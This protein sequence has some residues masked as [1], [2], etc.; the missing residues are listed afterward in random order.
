MKIKKASPGIDQ[1]NRIG[2]I[3]GDE[4]EIE[5]YDPD[6]PLESQVGDADV[7]LVRDVPVPRAVI[8][9]APRLKLVQRPGA[10][11]RDVDVAYARAQGIQICRIPAE[12]QGGG[13]EDVAEHAF[14]LMLALAKKHKE[15]QESFNRRMVG[16]PKTMRLRGKTLLLVGVGPTGTALAKIA[17]GAGMRVIAVK[18][19]P[20][21]MLK[22]ELN[23]AALGTM[24][25]LAGFIAEADVVSLHLPV[26][27]DTV[28]LIGAREI[29]AMKSGAL[30]INISRAPIVDRDALYQ[31]LIAGRIGGAGLD[32]FWEEPANPNDPLCTLDNVI[33]SP[34]IAGDT[35]E[36][37]ERLAFVTAENVRLV[38]AGKQANYQVD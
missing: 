14:Y 17:R 15:A 1:G 34:H 11:L 18:R 7:L 2:K 16:L 28:K 32:V 9:A 13:P 35:R 30:L 37:E 10:H 23:L 24:D 3:L 12:A 26:N 8:D 4:F 5:D 36:V 22:A 38:A 25:D 20:D 27:Q 19:T 29:G 31:G 21:D 33:V 6:R